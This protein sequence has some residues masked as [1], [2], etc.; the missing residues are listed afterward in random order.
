M[1]DRRHFVVSATAL[2]AT[3][4]ATGKGGLFTEA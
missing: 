1:L 3:A 2:A 4:P